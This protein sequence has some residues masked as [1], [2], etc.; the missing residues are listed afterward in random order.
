M[1]IIITGNPN[2]E[3]LCKGLYKAYNG[4]QLE[5]IGRHNGWDMQDLDAVADYIK[6]YFFA[7]RSHF[8]NNCVNAQ[9]INCTKG[10]AG[11]SH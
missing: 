8:C 10:C 5:F 9:F 4:N 2:Y 1:K 7:T 6:D 11:Y 3:G